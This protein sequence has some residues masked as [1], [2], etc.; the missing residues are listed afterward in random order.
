MK[1][2][3][4][5]LAIMFILIGASVFVSVVFFNGS[6]AI[7]S[8]GFPWGIVGNL[9]G[10]FIFLWIISWFFFPWRRRYWG[11]GSNRGWRDE[12]RAL[13]LLR[14]RYARGEI[15]KEQF[16]QMSNDLERHV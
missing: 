4:I 8:G 16:D 2:L 9:F 6:S 14:E 7:A 12:D 15:T 10:V 1:W 13:Q 11:W 5:G 3:W